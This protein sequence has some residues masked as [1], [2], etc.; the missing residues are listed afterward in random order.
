MACVAGGHIP[1]VD[2]RFRTSTGECFSIRTE[3]NALNIARMLGEGVACVA[4][5][6]IPQVDGRFRT[7]GECFSIRTEGNAPDTARMPGEQCHFVGGGGIVEPNPDGS[8]NGEQGTI[9]GICNL[10]DGAFAEAQGCAL[11]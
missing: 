5:G 10:V 1:Q 11:G 8:R 4:G 6:H 7:T 3:G 2:G 9:G